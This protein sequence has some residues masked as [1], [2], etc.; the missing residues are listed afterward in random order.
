[1]AQQANIHLMFYL[2]RLYRQGAS[3]I[4]SRAA[5]RGEQVNRKAAITALGFVGGSPSEE[6]S[7]RFFLA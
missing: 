4:I 2:F 5:E 3:L 7:L 6:V 1:M